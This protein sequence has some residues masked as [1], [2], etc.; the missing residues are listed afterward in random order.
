M[1]CVC[2]MQCVSVAHFALIHVVCG[3]CVAHMRMCVLMMGRS[4]RHRAKRAHSYAHV[5]TCVD[6][7]VR[8]FAPTSTDRTCLDQFFP[9]FVHH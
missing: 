7:C 9:L 8:V 5:C 4:T 6:V 1:W 2:V 3:V